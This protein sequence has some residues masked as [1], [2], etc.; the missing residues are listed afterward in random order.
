[1]LSYDHRV[2][3]D[4]TLCDAKFSNPG[5]LDCNYCSNIGP[6]DYRDFSSGCI[7]A[8]QFCIANGTAPSPTAIP[9]R[10]RIPPPRWTPSSTS[11]TP[12]PSFPDR[13]SS[14]PPPSLPSASPASGGSHGGH[15]SVY[16]MV[17]AIGGTVVGLTMLGIAIC[18]IWRRRKFQYLA[19]YAYAPYHALAVPEQMVN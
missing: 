1:M 18:V 19:G 2:Y 6:K 8:Q 4:I 13:A 14:P 9:S 7:S 15:T 3:R 12:A 11:S 16:I 10:T 5:C 17:G